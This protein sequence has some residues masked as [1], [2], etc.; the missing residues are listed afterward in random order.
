MV[1]RS[2]VGKYLTTEKRVLLE[3]NILAVNNEKT[4]Q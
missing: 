2:L 3:E 4:Q 1:T